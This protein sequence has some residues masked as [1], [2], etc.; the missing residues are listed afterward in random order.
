MCSRGLVCRD[1]RYD[2][3][4]KAMLSR[5]SELMARCGSADTAMPPTELYNEGWM[6]RLVLD[7]FER[8]RGVASPLQFE[9]GAR[10]YSEALLPS[11]FM[12]QYQGDRRAESFT[13]ADG[14][15]GHFDIQPG[16]RGAASLRSDTR[17]FVVCE[18]K[19]GSPLSFRT[20]NSA[21]F[22]QA[23]RNVAC[24]AY[25]IGATEVPL[26]QI[27]K[28]AFYVI[29]PDAQIGAGVFGQ[30]VTKE[31]VRAKVAARIEAYDGSMDEWYRGV[32]EPV[33]ERVDLAPRSWESILESMPE[34]AEV[35]G[36]RE[37]YAACLKFN[38]LRSDIAARMAADARRR[39]A[40]SAVADERP[41]C[42]ACAGWAFERWRG[43]CADGL[44]DP[45]PVPDVPRVVAGRCPRCGGTVG[46]AAERIGY[47]NVHGEYNT[48]LPD[49]FFLKI[50]DAPRDDSSG[51]WGMPYRDPK[52]GRVPIGDLPRRYL[53]HDW[54][55]RHVPFDL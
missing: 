27:R 17:Q 15:I 2:K 37:F 32:F 46:V 55:R 25:M 30:L 35:A 14:L 6:L 40:V 49:F 41:L 42:R 36:L 34:D 3:D 11:R 12:R 8:H 51:R 53:P 48:G 1:R 33:L 7:W 26:E 16:E 20:T 13:H 39:A 9:P 52:V 10:W 23:A 54:R 22:D 21:D 5:I 47:A 38:P 19:L 4:C 45:P 43:W 24:M 31:S 29:A 44:D 50:F 18:A 28:L